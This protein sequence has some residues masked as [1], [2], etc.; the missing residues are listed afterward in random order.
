MAFGTT[1]IGTGILLT[2]EDTVFFRTA[3]SIKAY[4]NMGSGKGAG[5]LLLLRV[6]YTKG[7]SEKIAWTDRELVK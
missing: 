6:Q 3:K 7:A 2:A 5:L 4:L 1:D